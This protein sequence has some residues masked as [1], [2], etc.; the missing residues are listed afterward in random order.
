MLLSTSPLPTPT[1]L[2]AVP[3]DGPVITLTWN[4]SGQRI[5]IERSIDIEMTAPVTDGWEVIATVDAGTTSYNDTMVG[6]F[7]YYTYRVR[8]V[9]ADGTMVSPASNIDGALLPRTH[10][11]YLPL[12]VR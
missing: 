12:V 5:Q 3:G 2:Q 11:L 10:Q 9:S 1:D 7:E 6:I 8:A 4:S